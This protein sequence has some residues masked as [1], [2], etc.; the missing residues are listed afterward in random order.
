M[1][2]DFLLDFL[3]ATEGNIVIVVLFTVLCRN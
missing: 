3:M 1:S 2:S